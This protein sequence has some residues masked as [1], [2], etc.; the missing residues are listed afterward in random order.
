M[1]CKLIGITFA[2]FIVAVNVSRWGNGDE[3]FTALASAVHLVFGLA[4]I[5]AIMRAPRYRNV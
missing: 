1:A 3:L 2:A 5:V 4:A